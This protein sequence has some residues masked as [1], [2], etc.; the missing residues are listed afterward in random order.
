M[1][2]SPQVVPAQ[3]AKPDKMIEP[4]LSP[5][6]KTSPTAIASGL[7]KPES[8][9][10]VSKS[11]SDLLVISANDKLVTYLSSL[12][13]SESRAEAIKWVLNR[14]GV[15]SGNLK[16]SSEW[17]LDDI[18]NDYQLI[19]YE[20]SGNL[21]RLTQL[22]YPAILEITLPNSLGTKY[23]ALLSIKKGKGFFGSVDR[24]EI[25]MKII[26]EL[27]N[28]KAIVLWRDF[29]SLPFSLSKGFKGKEAIWIQK[30]LRLLGFFK[31][32]ESPHY[33]PKTQQAVTL[34]QRKYGIKDDGSFNSETRMTAYRL[35]NIYPTP[36]LT[37]G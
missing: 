3:K 34:F 24:I 19:P 14:W 4:S 8:L 18:E 1:D 32:K 25:P 15:V 2:I 23:L 35:L 37:D 13:H 22:N 10:H 11:K 16:G 27:W 5:A 28:G 7:M 21:E 12:T 26:G 17:L 20:L 30:N 36:K 9:D 31:G 6:T 29:E 33:G